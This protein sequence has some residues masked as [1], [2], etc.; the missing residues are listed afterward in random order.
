[1]P[2]QLTEF[3]GFNLVATA[4]PSAVGFTGHIAIYN[5]NEDDPDSYESYLDAEFTTQREALDAAI[6]QG[7]GIVVKMGPDFQL[8]AL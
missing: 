2:K 4:Y 7:K 5:A 8:S 6:D 3:R 1:M